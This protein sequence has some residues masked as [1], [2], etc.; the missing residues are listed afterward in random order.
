[1]ASNLKKANN[2]RLT[3]VKK[4]EVLPSSEVEVV[5][6]EKLSLAQIGVLNKYLS[7][8][9]SVGNCVGALVG[10]YEWDIRPLVIENNQLMLTRFTEPETDGSDYKKFMSFGKTLQIC[11]KLTNITDF[12]STADQLWV[13]RI[14]YQSTFKDKFESIVQLSYAEKKQYII[15]LINLLQKL[16]DKKICHGNICL[17]NITLIESKPVFLDF[18]L[19]IITKNLRSIENIAPE[20]RCGEPL[21]TA[22][23]VYSLGK[24]I[25]EIIESIKSLP[26]A[27]L[28]N[29]M[30]CSD[31]KQRL[32]LY[33]VLEFFEDRRSEESPAP[34]LAARKITGNADLLK[35]R[36]EEI[37]TQ[38]V[39]L[40]SDK[41]YSR[42][43]LNMDKDQ[44]A[45]MRI[46]LGGIILGIFLAFYLYT[47]PLENE[48]AV[49]ETIYDQ[50]SY[51]ELWKSGQPSMMQIVVRAAAENNEKTAQFVIVKDVLGG[52]EYKFINSALIKTAFDPRWEGSLTDVDRKIVLI[53]SSAG[54]FTR[55]MP[56]M[57]A[58]SNASPIILLSI[59]G[60]LQID[61]P[62]TDLQ[63]IS[64]DRMTKL[65]SPYDK[66]FREFL[67]YKQAK[68]DD[69][70]IRALS[71][72]VLGNFDERMI[73]SFFVNAKKDVDLFKMARI[74]LPLLPFNKELDDQLYGFLV[75]RS[76]VFAQAY[77]WFDEENFS[78]WD[79]VTRGDKIAIVS[80]V[81]PEKQLPFEKYADLLKHPNPRISKESANIINDKFYSGKL[82]N[83]LNFLAS[84]KNRLTRYQT[85][86]ILA[87]LS[88]QGKE[89]I[90][91]YT[92][93]FHSN[94]D[95]RSV[96]ECLILRS[97][98]KNSDIFNLRAAQ[99]LSEKEWNADLQTLKRLVLHPESLARAQAYAKLDKNIPE[100]LSLLNAMSIAEPNSRLREQIR[101]GLEK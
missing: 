89:A 42:E 22:S 82:K 37:K 70:S 46:Y 66:A 97:D 43:G 99:Y 38:A 75:T 16:H 45:S 95:V 80:G 84:D 14:F 88:I 69:I 13:K 29:N 87:A 28:I 12:G 36:Y 54:L 48:I 5:S 31:P 35:T 26:L 30:T 92:K 68:L 18:G 33:E 34:Q 64:V 44:F 98:S 19:A 52:K 10:G 58:L 81:F 71:H 74:L 20:V 11:G 85:I 65:P 6:Y 7:T 90:D 9:D 56:Q 63:G 49:T 41:Q 67:N 73:E 47:R 78:N 100:H 55:D 101:L 60:A 39:E 3:L 24:V 25:E 57:P 32:K 62:I 93:W 4:D 96:L 61:T 40:R 23:D 59:M 83:L 76:K 53:L 72:I 1:M 51:A 86:S 17:S 50:D 8:T 15:D 79:S 21:S 27:A 94:P 2:S 77:R 91:F